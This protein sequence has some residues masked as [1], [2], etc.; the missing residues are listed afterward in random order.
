MLIQLC[1]TIRKTLLDELTGIL[2]LSET[3]LTDLLLHGELRFDLI[4]DNKI[5]IASIKS[6]MDYGKFIDFYFLVQEITFVFA[7]VAFLNGSF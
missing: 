3:A 2:K 4:Q 1:T 6:I 5:L 7:F